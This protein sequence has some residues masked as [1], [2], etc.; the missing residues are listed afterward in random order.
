MIHTDDS[1]IEIT[2]KFNITEPAELSVTEKVDKLSRTAVMAA[3]QNALAKFEKLLNQVQLPT[4]NN[5]ADNPPW[6]EF[7]FFIFES[8]DGSNIA[9][10]YQVQLGDLI[11]ADDEAPAKTKLMTLVDGVMSWVLGETGDL[12]ALGFEL[13]P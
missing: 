7:S 1:S 2:V 11:Y 10:T 3:T 8:H 4:R 5:D 6:V 13:L 9:R 12:A